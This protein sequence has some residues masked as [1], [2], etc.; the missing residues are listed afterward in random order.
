MTTILG[1]VALV[2]AG[3]LVFVVTFGPLYY[4]MTSNWSWRGWFLAWLWMLVC[5][6]V[7]IGCIVLAVH[8][9]PDRGPNHCADRGGIWSV[10]GHHTVHS[11]ATYTVTDY[12]CVMPRG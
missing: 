11:K 2:L 10:V 4:G 3:A 7:V 1:V 8:D 12:G 5:I 6:G 9:H